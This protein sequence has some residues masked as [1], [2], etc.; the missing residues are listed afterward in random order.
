MWGMWDMERYIS[1]LLGEIPRLKQQ[2]LSGYERGIMKPPLDIA[3]NIAEKCNTSI[4]WLCG[5]SKKINYDDSIKTYG[6]AIQ[7]LHRRIYRR[8]GK[9]ER[10]V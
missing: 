8:M 2:M 10:I 5:L 1:L 3:K 9:N 7:L 6:D 4:D